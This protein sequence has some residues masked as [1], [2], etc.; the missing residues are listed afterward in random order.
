MNFFKYEHLKQL[1]EFLEQQNLDSFDS[2]QL[3]LSKV[4]PKRSYH[5][6]NKLVPGRSLDDDFQ[7]EIKTPAKRRFLKS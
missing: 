3:E 2:S 7:D 5:F 6:F 1:L 4:D